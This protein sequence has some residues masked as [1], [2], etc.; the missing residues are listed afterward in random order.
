MVARAATTVKKPVAKKPVAKAAAKA[1][2]SSRPASLWSQLTDGQKQFLNRYDAAGRGRRV[3]KWNPGSAG[4]RTSTA[5]TELMRDRAIDSTRNDWQSASATQKWTTNLIGIGI[6]PRFKRIKAGDRKVEIIDLWNDWVKTADADGILNF[7]GMQTLAVREWV[8]SGEV[9][10]RIRSRSLDAG[11][12]VPMQ[13]QLLPSAFVPFLDTDT[14]PGLPVGNTIRQGIEFNKY[15]R[16]IAYWMYKEHPGDRPTT[17]SI[18]ANDLVRVPA[19][20][21]FHMFEPQQVGQIRGVTILHAILTKL[22]DIGNFEDATM[23]RQQIANLF[24]AFIKN[25]LPPGVDG[26]IDP[27]TGRPFA[28]DPN[29]NPLAELAPGIIQE[30]EDGQEVQFASPPKSDADYSNYLRTNHLG[31]AA[32]SGLPYEILSGDIRDVSDRTLRVVINEFRRFAEQRQW[33]I[34]IPMMC[35][36][37]IAAFSVNASLAGLVSEEEMNQIKRAE[38][39]P[40]GWAYIHPVQDPQGKKLEV[41]AGFRS[42]SSVIGERGDDPDVVDQERADDMQREKDLDIWIDPNPQPAAG[43]DDGTDN[44]EYSAPPNARRRS[45]R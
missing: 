18:G 13:V 23:L 9:F 19:S 33:Q 22:R 45:P 28:R 30:L 6:T 20:Q 40:H 24:V 7:Y 5:G 35:E 36:P 27:N 43:D 26:D 11:L 31:V 10:I 42:R 21:V 8:A 14:Y 39:S 4:P 16:R 29:G 12:P 37:I 3:A 44:D 1:V 41:E 34:V 15:S 2:D 17:A 38:W 25:T 32:G